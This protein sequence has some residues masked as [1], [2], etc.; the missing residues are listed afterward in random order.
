M[1]L[2]AV[3][4]DGVAPLPVPAGVTDFDALYEQLSGVVPGVYS[5]LRTF[6][7]N[8]FLDLDGHIARLRHSM[9][10]LG[11]PETLLDEA[12]LRRALHQVCSAYP[13]PEAR[14]RFDFLAEPGL[15]VGTSS[16]LLLAVMPFTPPPPE[17]YEQGVALGVAKGLTRERPLLKTADFPPQR[18]AYSRQTHT[19]Y[20]EYLLLDKQGYILEGTGSNFYAVRD[21]VV[22]TAESGIL[23]GI[24]RRIILDL[25]PPLGIPLRLEPVHID[26]IGRLDEAAMSSSSRALLPV[27]AIEEQTVGDGHPGPVSRRILAAYQEYVSSAVT[28]AVTPPPTN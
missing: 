9:A 5:V 22:Y 14:V 21:G 26:E 27:V 25:L 13:A 4:S 17:L 8:K 18:R 15:T 10:G 23:A 6:A 19:N 11:W 28:T 1:K 2:F 16:R 3:L 7:G 12:A 24:T 20:Y